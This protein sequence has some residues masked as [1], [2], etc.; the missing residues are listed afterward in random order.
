MDV[1]EA[2]QKSPYQV[3]KHTS[4]FATYERLFTPYKDKPITF[5]EVGVLNGGSLFMWRAFWGDNVRIIGVDMNPGAKRWED[6]GFEIHIGDQSDPNFW[7]DFFA[8]VGEVDILLDDGGHTFEQQIVTYESALPHIK[9]DGLLV[10]EDTHT[11]YM[12]DFGGPSRRSFV[13]FAKNVV[14]G[15]HYR[16]GNVAKKNFEEQVV[17]VSFFESIVAFI[18]NRSLAEEKA[19]PAVNGGESSGAMDYRHAESFT[20]STLNKLTHKY[21]H[22]KH[23]PIVG[24]ILAKTWSKLQI[25]LLW[26]IS[27]RKT[28]TMGKHFKY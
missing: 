21:V 11:S 6:E 8:Q 1:K 15:I 19:S 7:N 20:G 22:L 2:F 3:K 5:V 4:Y 17:A 27:K 23:L 25:L 26:L 12:P 10:V 24:K 14:D 28:L 9:D 18:V 16:S 13:S